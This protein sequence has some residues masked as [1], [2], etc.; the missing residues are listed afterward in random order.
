[1]TSPDAADGSKLVFDG[2]KVKVPGSA[3]T[4][5]A[6]FTVI[7]STLKYKFPNGMQV[8]ATING[9]SFTTNYGYVYKKVN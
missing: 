1:M 9:D 5:E 7:G 2:G 8:E 6:D 3:T 4:G